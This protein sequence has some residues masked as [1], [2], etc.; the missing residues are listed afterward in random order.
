[1]KKYNNSKDGVFDLRH[2]DSTKSFNRIKD[3]FNMV[4]ADP[5][6]FLS[7][8]GQTIQS[9]KIVS[10]N[11]GIWDKPD[12]S[13]FM[14]DFNSK[15]LSNVRDVMTDNAT[16]WISGTMHNIFNIAQLLTELNFKVLNVITWQ[17][18]NP[19]PNFACRTFT[20]ST[21]VIIWARK[22]KKVAH[23]YNYALMKKLNYNKQMKDVWAMPAFF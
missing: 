12:G 18:T 13:K 19:P 17:K 5:P 3:K 9:G 7:S 22:E 1:M 8:G 2:G 16:I 15:W 20:H 4:F 11:K 23:F 14:Y 21:E 10:V 6:Y